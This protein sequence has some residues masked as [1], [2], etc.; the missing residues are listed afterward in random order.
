VG[1][2]SLAQPPAI[3][4]QPSAC[5]WSLHKLTETTGF[6][7]CGMGR[8]PMPRGTGVPPVPLATEGPL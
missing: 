8:M 1:L 5:L 2:R 6:R 3:L 7:S 4:W